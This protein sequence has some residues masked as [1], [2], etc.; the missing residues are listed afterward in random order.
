M[1]IKVVIADDSDLMMVGI[2]AIIETD[3]HYN[4]V[5]ASQTLGDILNIVELHVPEI[6]ILSECLY[7]SDVLSAV[8][9]IRSKSPNTFVLVVGTTSDGVLIH[10]LFAHGVKGYLFRSDALRE[11]LLPAMTT[12]LRNRPYLSPTANAEYLIMLQS[13]QVVSTLDAEARKVLNYLTQGISVNQIAYQM[14]TSPRRIYAIRQRLRRRFGVETNE[15]LIS[16]A[17]AEG[18]TILSAL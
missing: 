14:G 11:C 3:E 6:A 2:Q 10:N 18:F 7:D 16:R 4:V 5:G 12:V 8:E 13:R 17:V 1:T 15:H 9:S